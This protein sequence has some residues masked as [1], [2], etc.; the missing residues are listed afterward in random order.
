MEEG[1]ILGYVYRYR[2]KEDGIIKYVGIVY[3][4]TRTLEARLREHLHNDDWCNKNFSIEYINV[5]IDNRSE[6]EAFESHYISL[7]ETYKY[8]NKAKQHWGINKY[9]PDRE[10]DFTEYIS[11]YL[12]HD[13]MTLYVTRGNYDV[14][15]YEVYEDGDYYRF[16]NKTLKPGYVRKSEVGRHSFWVGYTSFNKKEAYLYLKELALT[17][18]KRL[19]EE[20]KKAISAPLATIDRIDLVLEQMK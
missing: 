1:S 4:K 17:T 14:K 2:D 8:F 18:M 6:A 11:P 16:V 13:L 3:G 5:D 15:G 12:K 10:S 9:L 7:Y 20:Y 19:E